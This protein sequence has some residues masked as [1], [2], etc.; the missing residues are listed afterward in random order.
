M[1]EQEPITPEGFNMEIPEEKQEYI[2]QFAF[3]R[4]VAREIKDNADWECEETG[5]KASDGWKMEACHKN[6]DKNYPYYNSLK[7][8]L[9]VYNKVVLYILQE[10]YNQAYLISRSGYCIIGHEKTGQ[11]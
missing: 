11:Y 2:S 4:D 8:F 5:R 9:S 6:H 7:T 3:S 1:F 10:R